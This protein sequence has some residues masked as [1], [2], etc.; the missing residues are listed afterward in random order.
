MLVFGSNSLLPPPSLYM[1]VN[2]CSSRKKN[3]IKKLLKP[4]LPKRVH[5]PQPSDRKR[6]F[7]FV[8]GSFAALLLLAASNSLSKGLEP[9]TVPGGVA[10]RQRAMLRERVAP[11][12][13]RQ[14]S[15]VRGPV[16]VQARDEISRGPLA[17]LAPPPT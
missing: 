7:L 16:G 13:G 6:L 17:P 12:P 15:H 3:K 1:Q 9:G 11:P 14:F 4:L 8:R 10:T 5:S 2:G